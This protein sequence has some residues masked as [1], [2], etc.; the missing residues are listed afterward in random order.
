MKDKESILNCLNGA[1]V[2]LSSLACDWT[3]A[4]LWRRIVETLR[5]ASFISAPPALNNIETIFSSFL[6]LVFV[7]VHV[8]ARIVG[9][10]LEGRFRVIISVFSLA[11]S[12]I[13]AVHPNLHR[14]RY[15]TTRLD[16]TVFAW[17]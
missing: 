2:D 4:F 12:S 5:L 9:I 6:E 17:N 13:K 15:E 7:V 11:L 10:H 3:A 16:R 1:N 8:S 14:Y